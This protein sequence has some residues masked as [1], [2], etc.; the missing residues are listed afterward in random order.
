LP[1][2]GGLVVVTGELGLS[3]IVKFHQGHIMRKM[4]VRSLVDLVRAAE[5]LELRRPERSTA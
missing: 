4:G 2:R 3:E 5:P 1:K